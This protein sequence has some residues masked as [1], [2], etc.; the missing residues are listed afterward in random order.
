MTNNPEARKDMP[1]PPPLLLPQ[2][3]V[4][5]G[6][7]SPFSKGYCESAIAITFSVDGA[8]RT[9]LTKFLGDEPKCFVKPITIRHIQK[10]TSYR[11]RTGRMRLY[12]I[13]V[14]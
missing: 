12:C 10:H 2:F 13:V 11:D 8:G 5:K 4:G 6:D 14:Y 3:M 7:A 9:H 1:P